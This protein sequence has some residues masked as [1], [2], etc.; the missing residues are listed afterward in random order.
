MT[1]RDGSSSPLWAVTSYYNPAGF[2]SRRRNYQ[3]FRRSLGVPLLT[4]ELGY[5]ESFELGEGDADRLIQI[6]GRDV[7]WQKE[8]LLNIAFA[9]LPDHCEKVVWLDCDVM[10]N[11]EAWVAAAS[12]ALDHHALIQ[13]FAV[14]HELPPGA[15]D[16]Q[17]DCGVISTMTPLAGELAARPLDQVLG[18]PARPLRERTVAW[19]FAWAARRELLIEHG[20]YDACIIGGG[21]RAMIC[22][23]MGAL[24]HAIAPLRM[25]ERWAEHY[26]AWA[27]RFH[28]AVRGSVGVSNGTLLHLW[29]GAFS[30][31]RYR[32]RHED[33]V[34][35]AFDP[36]RDL[37][38]E[39]SGCWRWN[40]DKPG[41]HEFVRGYFRDRREDD[42]PVAAVG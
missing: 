1:A 6:R 12:D 11:D 34:A 22:A 2:S 27:Q 19:G 29:H 32:S 39:S 3:V 13:P 21:D 23:A 16:A 41:L 37:T 14:L 20:L 28:A 18:Q 7:M 25:N 8:R 15:E 5:G 31:R 10:F 4:V 30:H 36:G 26:M 17:E 24:E 40:C 33:L 9:E 38:P 42:L 35:H